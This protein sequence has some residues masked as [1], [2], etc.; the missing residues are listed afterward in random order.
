MFQRF[1]QVESSELELVVQVRTEYDSIFDTLMEFLTHELRKIHLEIEKDTSSAS[2]SW[3]AA[4]VGGLSVGNLSK[5]RIRSNGQT[6]PF[7]DDIRRKW[8]LMI[9]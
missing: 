7:F 4:R 6:L 9:S 2:R 8:S 1:L 5:G 3:E